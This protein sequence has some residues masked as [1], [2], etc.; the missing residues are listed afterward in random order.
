VST[1]TP[2][3]VVVGSGEAEQVLSLCAAI[4]AIAQAIDDN[5]D[6]AVDPLRADIGGTHHMLGTIANEVRD[7]VDAWLSVERMIAS[8]EAER[9]PACGDVLPLASVL[10]HRA[11]FHGGVDQ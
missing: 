9:C 4:D 6:R 10:S 5:V 1:Q 2:T 3:P 8:G 7:R 11:H